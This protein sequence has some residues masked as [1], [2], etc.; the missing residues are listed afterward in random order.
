MSA[1]KRKVMPLLSA[2]L[3]LFHDNTS[4]IAPAS[5]GSR[6]EEEGRWAERTCS[7]RGAPL[8]YSTSC[9]VF[10]APFVVIIVY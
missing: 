4:F 6:E 10:G 9:A 8:H 3:S 7:K 1:V 5:R 2:D